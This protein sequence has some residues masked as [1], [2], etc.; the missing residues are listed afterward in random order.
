MLDKRYNQITFPGTHNSG[1]YLFRDKCDNQDLDI[2]TQLDYGIRHIELD[3]DLLLNVFHAECHS[4]LSLRSQLEVVRDYAKAHPRQVITVKIGDLGDGLDAMA[5]L[6]RANRTLEDSNLD[7]Y[8]FN[9][10]P[11]MGEATLGKCYIPDPW[12]TMREMIESG[13]NVMFFHSREISEYNVIDEGMYENLGY[14]NRAL[15]YFYD[16]YDLEHLHKLNTRWA[17]PRERQ[18]EL[19]HHL[20]LVECEPDWHAWGGSRLAA[21]RNNDGRKLYQLARYQEQELLPDQRAVNFIIVDYFAATAAGH[22][23]ID[24]VDACNRLNYERF[25]IDW[26]SS[27]GFWELYPYEFD[28]SKVDVIRRVRSLKEEVA[29][30]YDDFMGAVDLDGH[31]RRGTIVATGY[32]P[33]VGDWKHLPEWAVDDDFY[34]RWCGESSDASDAWGI[35]LG[36]SRAIDEIA[37]AWEYPRRRPGYE[38]YASNDD[39]K[40]ADGISRTELADDTGWNLVA[41]G[42][43]VTGGGVR[44]WDR[45]SFR[46]TGT[47]NWRYVKVKVTDAGEYE[48]PT[49]YELRLFG[50][51]HLMTTSFTVLEK[52]SERRRAK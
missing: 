2:Q 37:I 17:P 35:D 28:D 50:P 36:D 33:G 43:R 19:P 38:V 4:L 39:S 21:S 24:V 13:R 41:A 48:R 51:N 20:F 1:S 32:R 15:S 26:K 10:D 9:W 45:K 14:G 6:E 27:D 12:P 23:P 47:S 7:D 25:G 5:L 42:T 29:A 22:L 16:A 30:A 44:L 52:P 31:E 49:F 34:T 8:V 18:Q 3:V 46:D 11:T 40:F